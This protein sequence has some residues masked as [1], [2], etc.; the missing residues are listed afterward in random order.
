MTSSALATAV[1]VVPLVEV[2]PRRSASTAPVVACGRR[3]VARDQGL[4]LVRS[5]MDLGVD[6]RR[7]T[8]G[9]LRGLVDALGRDEPDRHVAPEP[10]QVVLVQ[11]PEEMRLAQDLVLLGVVQVGQRRHLLQDQVDPVEPS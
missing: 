3:P 6:L 11:R 10:D 9:D 5:A 7:R 2:D 4:G 8:P 1:G